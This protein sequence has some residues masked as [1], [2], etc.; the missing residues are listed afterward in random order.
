MMHHLAVTGLA[1]TMVDTTGAA[2]D[3]LHRRDYQIVLCDLNFR[4][5]VVR[6][7]KQ[8]RKTGYQGPIIVVTAESAPARLAEARAAGAN[9]IIGKPHNP[10]YLASLLAEWLE[11]PPVDRPIY[12]NFEEKPGMPELILEF[13]EHARRMANQLEKALDA[14]ETGGVREVCLTLAGSG[15]SHGFP[16][17]TDAARD[18]LTAVDTAQSRQDLEAPVRRLIAICDRLRC[19][20]SVRPLKDEWAGEQGAA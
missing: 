12:S 8:I 4:G 20:N 17:L 9:E 16:A 18:A 2:L 6:M 10:L 14:G 5:D 1:M 3:A 19:G 13:I 11:A 7:I 15:G